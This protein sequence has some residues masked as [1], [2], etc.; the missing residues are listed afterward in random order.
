MGFSRFLAGSCVNLGVNGMV[1]VMAETELL[2]NPGM[3]G[4][5]EAENREMLNVEDSPAS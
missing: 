2:V 5:G 4:V 1:T 3:R